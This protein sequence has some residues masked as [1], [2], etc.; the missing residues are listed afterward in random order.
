MPQAA[1]LQDRV[2]FAVKQGFSPRG[3]TPAG[4]Y[5][6]STRAMRFSKDS[7]S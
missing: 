3:H 6:S 4:E 2:S 1:L 7:T 5:S